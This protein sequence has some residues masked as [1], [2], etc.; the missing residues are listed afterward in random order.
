ML[1]LV[2]QGGTST[3]G[4]SVGSGSMWD[5]GW[6]DFKNKPLQTFNHNLGTTDTTVYMEIKSDK[7]YTI[8]HTVPIT[9]KSDQAHLAYG[10]FYTKWFNKTA[11]TIDV[12]TANSIQDQSD[13]YVRIVL[14]RTG[15]GDTST[16]TG[17]STPSSTNSNLTYVNPDNTDFA[18]LDCTPGMNYLINPIAFS[19]TSAST[20]TDKKIAVLKTG[21]W[22][23]KGTNFSRNR[24]ITSSTTH[25]LRV[26]TV[27]DSTVTHLINNTV[28][29]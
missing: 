23:V 6:V 18:P 10:N 19:A 4:C 3:S 20:Y 2:A 1:E 17:N 9:L 26:S 29:V 7:D 27:L 24:N 11:N 21:N 25:T 28:D 15:C 14:K 22:T 16:S 12:T 8:A 5:S 13:R